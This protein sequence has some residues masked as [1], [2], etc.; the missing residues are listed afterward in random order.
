MKIVEF[1]GLVQDNTVRADAFPWFALA[2]CIHGL[3]NFSMLLLDP[4]P[5]T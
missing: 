4:F 3:Y 2:T 1:K 5:K